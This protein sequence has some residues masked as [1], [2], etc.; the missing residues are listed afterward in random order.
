MYHTAVQQCLDIVAC[1][2]DR[3][4]T[5]CL[6]IKACRRLFSYSVLGLG[7]S[8]CFDGGS[9]C[10]FPNAMISSQVRDRKSV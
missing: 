7:M 8:Q 5:I 2:S 3:S 6:V 4:A 10:H 1:L 9:F